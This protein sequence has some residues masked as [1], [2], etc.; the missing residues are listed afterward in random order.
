MSIPINHNS[1]WLINRHCGRNCW[2]LTKTH[3]LHF[4]LAQADYVSHLPVRCGHVDNGMWAEVMHDTSMPGPMHAPLCPL[5]KGAL[6]SVEDG[7]ASL[8]WAPKW[9]HDREPPFWPVHLPEINF[10]WA[11]NK[12]LLCLSHNIFWGLFY[13]SKPTLTNSDAFFRQKSAPYLLKSFQFWLTSWVSLSKSIN[14]L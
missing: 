14:H 7:T 1:H 6:G 8:A 2:L 13:G 9:L 12:L 11:R 5:G 10:M 4:F 3:V